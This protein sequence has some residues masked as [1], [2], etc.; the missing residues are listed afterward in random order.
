MFLLNDFQNCSSDG[1][2]AVLFN[3]YQVLHGTETSPFL[4]YPAV[5]CSRGKF[6]EVKAS[7]QYEFL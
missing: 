5:Y 3:G 7:V 1:T 6:L 2:G 4:H